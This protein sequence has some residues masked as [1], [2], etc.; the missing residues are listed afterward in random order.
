MRQVYRVTAAGAKSAMHHCLVWFLVVEIEYHLATVCCTAYRL[1]RLCMHFHASLFAAEGFDV[2][3][4]GLRCCWTEGRQSLGQV[5]LQRTKSERT[6]TAKG[7]C[8][9]LSF[10][11]QARLI[12]TV[13]WSSALLTNPAFSQ[14]WACRSAAAFNDFRQTNLTELRWLKGRCH[15]NQ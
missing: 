12:V 6:V 14:R 8:N 5:Q 4:R 7:E 11:K 1:Y 2:T 13:F 9:S 10:R 3:G 15:G